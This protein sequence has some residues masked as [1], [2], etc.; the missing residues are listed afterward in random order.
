MF[1]A[2]KSPRRHI[3]D[4]QSRVVEHGLVGIDRCSFRVV[5]NDHLGDRIGDP[6]E[7]ALVLTQLLLCLL[8]V[9]DVSAGGVP[10]YDLAALVTQRLGAD[11]KPAKYSI[12]PT[13]ARLD[14][15]RLS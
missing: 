8:T 12:V 4:G 5:D 3:I 10:L 9:F 6:A 15:P 2:R 7:L 13:K 1:C 14:L 11:E